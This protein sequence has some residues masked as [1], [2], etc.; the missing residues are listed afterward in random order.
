MPNR[1]DDDPEEELESSAAASSDRDSMKELDDEIFERLDAKR[2]RTGGLLAGLAFLVALGALGWA[3]LNW[4]TRSHTPVVDAE[5]LRALGHEQSELRQEFESLSARAADAGKG[6]TADEVAS[7][8]SS[9]AEQSSSTQQLRRDL[10]AQQSHVRTLQSALEA[11]QARLLAAETSLAAKVPQQTDARGRLELAEIDYLLRLASERLKLFSDAR[12]ADQALALAD[13]HLAALDNPIYLGVRQH[14]AEA[15]SALDAVDWPNE[16]ELSSTIDRLQGKVVGLAFAAD[17]SGASN[18][19]AATQEDSGWWSRLKA[20]LASLVT[21][22]HS[23]DGDSRLTL[24]D[25]ELLR[26][27]LWMQMESAR[28]AMMRHDEIAWQDALS[29]TAKSLE[30]W[31]DPE[32]GEFAEVRDSLDKLAGVRVAPELPDISGPWAQLQLIRGAP[33]AAPQPQDAAETVEEVPQE[34]PSTTDEPEQAET[35]ENSQ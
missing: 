30:R 8:K 2:G 27:G 7:L 16:V 24:E 15:R 21:V 9:L 35:E 11:T 29:R 4:W 26:Q 28:L 23:Q 17:G 25:K 22:R 10:E 31:F 12:S 34:A 19:A 32:K 33:Q 20:S 1:F 6:P 18:A 14:I 3:G 5:Q 13:D